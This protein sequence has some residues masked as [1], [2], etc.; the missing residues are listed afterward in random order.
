MTNKNSN[1]SSNDNDAALKNKLKQ[2]QEKDQDKKD[3]LDASTPP[4]DLECGTT[5]GSMDAADIPIPT[6]LQRND[7]NTG[8]ASRPGAFARSGPGMTVSPASAPSA[9]QAQH[10]DNVGD[11]LIT[12]Q[13]V[14]EDDY[15]VETGNDTTTTAVVRKT[16]PIKAAAV[17][18][19][20]DGL[21]AADKTTAV[22]W[23]RRNICITAGVTIVVLAVVISLVVALA[24]ASN[25]SPVET[26]YV[27]V[28]EDGVGDSGEDEPSGDG[29]Y[30]D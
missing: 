14:V 4:T 27:P 25:N 7:Q 16:L 8:P 13:L 1:Q 28:D 22:F 2:E 23:T 9:E 11:I 20:A 17:A 29:D 19:E 10:D 24:Q 21:M 15:D 12:A 18:E 30:H 5:L 6:T 26:I 3:A